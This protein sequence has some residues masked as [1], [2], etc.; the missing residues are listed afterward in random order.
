MGKQPGYGKLPDVPAALRRAQA[1][2]DEAAEGLAAQTITMLAPQVDH[3]VQTGRFALRF[4]EEDAFH[5]NP[6]IGEADLI[7]IANLLVERTDDHDQ[8]QRP[9]TSPR[10]MARLMSLP[11][12]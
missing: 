11:P 1:E 2:L 7:R 3:A 8:P 10:S 12:G 6:D 9:W 5:P 4:R